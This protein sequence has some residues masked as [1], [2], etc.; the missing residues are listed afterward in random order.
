MGC[1][2]CKPSAIEDSK[3]SPRERVSNKGTSDSRATRVASSRREEAYRAKDRYDSNDGRTMLIDKH[4]NGAARSHGENYERKREKMEYVAALHPGMGSIPKA[5]E[6]EQVAAGWPSW[7]AGV[8]GEAIKGWIPRRAD[9]FE[10]LD[11]IGQGTYSNVY[12][13]RDLDQ[14]KIVAL[15]K[16]RF[17]NSEPE[18]VRFMARE[19]LILRKL[20]HENVIK[21]EG[22][23]TSR[24]SC[25]LYLVFEYMEHDLAGLALHPGLKFT[26]AQVKCYMQQ[27]LCG[28]DHCHSRGVLHRDI[29]GSNLL[30]DNS[31]MLKIADF[32][33]ASIFD[34][35]QYQPLTSRVVT[36]WYRPPELLLGATYYGTAVDLW[37]TGCILAELY[38]GKPIMPGRTEVEQLHKIFKLCGSPSEDYWR[39]SKLPH[40]TIFKPQQPYRR[41]VAETFKDFP[42]PALA[43]MDTLL[44]IDPADRGS[45]SSALKSEFFTTKP[46]PCDPSSLPKYPPSKEFDVKV[47]DEEARRQGAAGKGHR[48][49]PERRGTRESRAIPAPDANAELVMSMQ[50][51][52]DQ[53]SS[54][55]RSEK[56]NPHPEEVASGFPIDPPR[57][58]HAVEPSMESHGHNHK[59]ASHSGPLSHRAAWA[60]STK[61]PDDAPKISNGADLS[62][63]SGLVAARRSMLTEE[64][65]KRSNSSQIDVPKVMGRFPGSFKEV[66]DP[67]A[68]DQKP[69]LGSNR[70]DDVRS[71]K[72]PIIVGYGSKGHKIHYSGPL[73]VPSGNMDQMLKDH[74]FQVQEA[75]RRARIDKAK[76]RKYQ[77]ESNPIST[78]SLFVSGR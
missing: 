63:M 36:L 1:M 66:S 46:L 3:E 72:D 55:S 41:C 39:K 59:R 54:K 48:H 67:S 35:H 43:L 22:L 69:V 33:L 38:A 14:K 57:P 4:S 64:R 73:L 9:S 16:V 62:G 30:I 5:V 51:R 70:K 28:L 24:M 7:L 77:A 21:L 45:A 74:D 27:L 34:P 17:D 32:G 60:K 42:V 25:S 40:A 65:R 76:V 71:N 50:K 56:F 18:S 20:D 12:R 31:G 19:I 10:K 11:K 6:G 8:A 29:K 61:N 13:A 47:R 75:V 53:S 44:S 23:V 58:S 78:N 49:D 68:H 26:E 37:S 52:Q 15:K 2:Y